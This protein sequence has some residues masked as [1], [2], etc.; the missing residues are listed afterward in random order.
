MQMAPFAS[1]VCVL[2]VIQMLFNF[3]YD[4][5]KFK[6]EVFVL[7]KLPYDASSNRDYSGRLVITVNKEQE[8][9]CDNELVCFS[10]LEAQ[11]K[12]HFGV[13]PPEKRIVLIK[14]SKELSYDFVVQIVDTAKA[15]KVLRIELQ[16]DF[17]DQ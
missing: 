5:L 14:A 10:D 15:A 13:T 4:P 2:V 17:L 1:I 9:Y 7:Q 8:I 16:V 12:T 6:H 3:P 11:V